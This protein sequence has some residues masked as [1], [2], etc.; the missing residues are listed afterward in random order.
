MV[1]MD[2]KGGVSPLQGGLNP[3]SCRKHPILS[4]WDWIFPLKPVQKCLLGRIASTE[5]THG[6]GGVQ[7]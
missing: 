1:F 5:K 2:V 7:L 6:E 4:I 3:S